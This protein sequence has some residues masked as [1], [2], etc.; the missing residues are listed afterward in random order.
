[1][2]KIKTYRG[3]LTDGVQQKINLKT[4]TGKMGYRIVKFQVMPQNPGTSD[5]EHVVQIFTIPK[6]D[7]TVYGDIDF[8]DQNL[9]GVAFTK[10]DTSQGNP[11][12]TAVIFDNVIFNQDIFVT[13]ADVKGALGANYHIELEQVK[14]NDNESTMATLQSIRTKYEATTPAGPT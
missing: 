7:P 2:S 13:H 10:G 14:L 4:N 8:S 9:L 6:T 3:L 1:M 12:D 11:Y 5:Y